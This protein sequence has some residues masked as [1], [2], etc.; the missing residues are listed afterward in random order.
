MNKKMKL[1]DKKLIKFMLLTAIAVLMC[2]VNV[3]AAGGATAGLTNLANFFSDIVK[4]IGFILGVFSITILG[5]GISQHDGSQIRT[6][7]LL[8]AGAAIMFFHTQ[9][10]SLMGITI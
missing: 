1:T 2:P 8:L 10:L 4:I 5:P 7:L 3:F 9:I 6:G